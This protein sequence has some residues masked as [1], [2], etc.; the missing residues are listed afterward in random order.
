MS[1]WIAKQPGAGNSR[2][3]RL[4]FALGLIAALYITAVILFIVFY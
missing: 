3:R 4:G 1:E 2:N